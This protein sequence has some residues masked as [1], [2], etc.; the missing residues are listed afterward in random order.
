MN[1]PI[2]KTVQELDALTQYSVDLDL[3]TAAIAGVIRISRQQGRSLDDLRH[4]VLTDHNLLNPQ[5]RAQLSEIL[6]CAWET[7]PEAT[8]LKPTSAPSPS[9][10]APQALGDQ[11]EA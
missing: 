8:D 10:P 11:I 3:I 4:E 6:T 1:Y 7:L 5:L 2:P 9:H